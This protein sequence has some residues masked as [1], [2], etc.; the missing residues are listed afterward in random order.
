MSYEIVLPLWNALRDRFQKK[1]AGLSEKDV[2]LQLGETSIGDLLYHT[3]EV[4]YMFSEWFFDKPKEKAMLRPEKIEGYIRLLE[5][6]NRHFLK[7]MNELPADA[8]SETKS[9][10]FGE[11]TPLEAV[12]RLMNHAGM[13][14][15]QMTFIQKYGQQETK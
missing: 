3:A 4:E 11:S 7:A 14:S 12:G 1:V 15:G 13:H 10:S 6:S 9:S 8:W 2:N 5:D